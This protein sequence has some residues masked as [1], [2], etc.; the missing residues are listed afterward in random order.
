MHEGVTKN[1]GS[2]EIPPFSQKKRIDFFFLKVYLCDDLVMGCV[3]PQKGFEVQVDFKL[4][5]F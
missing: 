3:N 5:H 2:I 1:Q 4:M